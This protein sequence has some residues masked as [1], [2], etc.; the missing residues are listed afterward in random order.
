MENKKDRQR[1]LCANDVLRSGRP[2][3]FQVWFCPKITIVA[4]LSESI[5][6]QNSVSQPWCALRPVTSPLVLASMPQFVDH[7][8]DQSTLQKGRYHYKKNDDDKA[9]Q[10]GTS[11]SALSKSTHHQF[12]YYG[13]IKTQ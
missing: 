1:I 10:H 8:F 9:D 7:D 11:C 4:K 13:E 3:R 12:H 5:R 2:L 6:F